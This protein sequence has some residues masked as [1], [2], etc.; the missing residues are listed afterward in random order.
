MASFCPILPILKMHRG[1]KV[2]LGV[3]WKNEGGSGK[4]R[5]K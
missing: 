4:Q 5:Q 2:V 3:I 1:E